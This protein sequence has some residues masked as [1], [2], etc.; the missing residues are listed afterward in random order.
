VPEGATKAEV[1]ANHLVQHVFATKKPAPKKTVIAKRSLKRLN[2]SEVE[3]AGPPKRSTRKK[4]VSMK[5]R[6]SNE[7]VAGG[8]KTRFDVQKEAQSI[9]SKKKVEV[10]KKAAVKGSLSSDS[11]FGARKRDNEMVKEGT[12]NIFGARKRDN[13]MI[14]EG[15]VAAPA[16]WAPKISVPPPK[17]ATAVS[18]TSFA[19][20]AKTATCLIC[21]DADV[22]MVVLCCMNSFHMHCIAQWLEKVVEFLLLFSFCLLKKPQKTRA[23]RAV[24]RV[25]VRFT[26]SWSA[27]HQG[28]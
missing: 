10:T 2:V 13:G 3:A 27:S 18:R 14:K 1:I 20:E 23:T 4:S 12:V 26:G 28:K 15:T 5:Y 22:N 24:P 19:D 25:A 11:I 6:E 7:K 21:F 16:R 9:L 17:V 8:V